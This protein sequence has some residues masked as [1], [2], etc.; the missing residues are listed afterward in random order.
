MAL[1]YDGHCVRKD[2]LYTKLLFFFT[3]ILNGVRMSPFSTA[4][5]IDL[6]YQP[7]IIDVGDC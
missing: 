6:F 1:Y 5:T 4:T 7:Q 2:V 3:I